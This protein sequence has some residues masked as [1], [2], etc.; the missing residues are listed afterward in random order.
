MNDSGDE[1]KEQIL[2]IVF[3]LKTMVEQVTYDVTYQECLNEIINGEI[4]RIDNNLYLGHESGTVLGM[5]LPLASSTVRLEQTQKL[6]GVHPC[7]ENTNE[8]FIA[9]VK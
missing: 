1:F 9:V 3:S 5:F 8:I 7:I 4:F 2:S 6:T